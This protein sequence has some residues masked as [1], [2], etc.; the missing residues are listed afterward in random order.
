MTWRALQGAVVSRPS[1][2]DKY[3]MLDDDDAMTDE[4]LLGLGEGGGADELAHL[5]LPVELS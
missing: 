5:E 2:M 1:R 4:A 3:S